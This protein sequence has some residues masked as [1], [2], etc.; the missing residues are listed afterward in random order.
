M[1]PTSGAASYAA[2]VGSASAAAAAPSQHARWS[3]YELNGGTS[4][5]LAGAGFAVIGAD[6]RL[7][8]GYSIMTRNVARTKV[9]TDKCVI[10]TGGCHT[11]VHT[12]HKTLGVR[13]DTYRHDHDA[14]MSCTA[15]AQ[16]LGNTLYFRRFFPYYAF[17]VS[18]ARQR[19][20]ALMDDWAACAMPTLLSP[21]LPPCLG[22]QVVA[23][24]DSEGKGAVYTYD[25]VGSFE[26]VEYAAQGSGQKLII[27]LLDDLVGRRNRTDAKAPLTV[28]EAIELIK[29]CFVTAGER[30][31]Y[32][33]DSVDIVIVTAAGIATERFELKKD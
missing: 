12:L 31:I 28:A 4:L 6:T 14:D 5:A 20:R 1:A 9:L 26:R 29:E 17:N 18:A 23:G 10:A 13:I 11:D 24:I 33:G 15:V 27:P 32:T 21:V 19:A 7:S 30:D 25:A 22:S 8:E 3:P 16:M 2:M